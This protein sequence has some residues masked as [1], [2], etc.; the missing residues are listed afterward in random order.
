MNNPVTRYG[1]YK[2]LK[3]SPF[4]ITLK[5]ITYYFSNKLHYEK[6]LKQFPVNRANISRSLS[7][8]FKFDIN[9]AILA[10][11]ALYLKIENRGT[12]IMNEEGGIIECQKS[13]LLNGVKL[14]NNYCKEK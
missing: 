3:H 9:Q 13:L 6:F 14:T 12:L 4:K 11:V 5:G 7:K 1:V 2:S 10:D 8:R